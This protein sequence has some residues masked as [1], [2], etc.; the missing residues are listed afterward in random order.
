MSD[1]QEGVRL[2]L[3][4]HH[5]SLITNGQPVVSPLDAAGKE[6]RVAR[7]FDVVGDVRQVRA[8]R[9]QLFDVI[10]RAFE[11]EVRRVR[12][13]PQAVY[14]ERVEAAEQLFRAVGYLAQVCQ[15]SEVVEAVAG[16]GE[17]AVDDLDRRDVEVGAEA[18]GRAVFDGVGV[19]L[20]EAS[21]EVR[22]LEDVPE[23]AAD[24]APGALVGVDA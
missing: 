6:R 23:D 13:D 24:V 1:E 20:R 9:A 22:R 3:I 2:L 15:I 14:D 12:L 4:T 8:A 18:E 17:P 10:E 19:D 7:V 11:P 16:D 5:S 21:A